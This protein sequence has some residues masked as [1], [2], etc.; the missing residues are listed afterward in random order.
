MPE[1][2][3]ILLVEDN[4]ADVYRVEKA[5]QRRGIVYELERYEDGEQAI[6]ALEDPACR[7]PD[8][9]LIDLNL[10]RREGFDVVTAIRGKPGLVGVPVGI[11]TSSDHAKDRHRIALLGVER[12]IHKSPTLEEFL[13]Q[14][15]RAIADLVAL[16]PKRSP[17]GEA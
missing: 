1:T 2:I 17:A 3:R 8:L 15:G 14:V 10:P 11:L 5:L 13:E 9:F 16:Q 6:R 7:A 4:P 12:Y